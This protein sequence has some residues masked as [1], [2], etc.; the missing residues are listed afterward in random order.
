VS[1]ISA[2]TSGDNPRPADDVGLLCSLDELDDYT[3]R[4]VIARL[5]RSCQLPTGQAETLFDDAVRWLWLS[6]KWEI[7]HAA[8]AP[9]LPMQWA[10]FDG[11]DILDYAWH[12]F[13]LHTVDYAEFCRRYLGAF[14]H[15]RPA[16][17]FVEDSGQFPLAEFERSLSYAWD[18]LGESTVRRWLTDYPA[19]SRAIRDHHPYLG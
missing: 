6:R 9:D 4:G 11:L 3:H 13:I 18:H 5:E 14:I 15:H 19:L 8:G 2:Q 16:D 7:D 12:E 17:P 1:A 10:M